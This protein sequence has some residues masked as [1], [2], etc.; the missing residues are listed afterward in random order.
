MFHL[1]DV[2]TVH[3]RKEFQALHFPYPK[4]QYDLEGSWI[5][6][7]ETIDIDIITIDHWFVDCTVFDLT[8]LRHGNS[9][10]SLSEI[11]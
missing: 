1:L 11:M 8:S 6:E 10:L 7:I 2:F 4:F 3:N 5:I 9:V